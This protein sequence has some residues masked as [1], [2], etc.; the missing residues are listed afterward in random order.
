MDP[1]LQAQLALAGEKAS[2]WRR[3]RDEL[4]CAARAQGATLR[5][6]AS[7]VGLTDP[8]VLHIVRRGK[9][10]DSHQA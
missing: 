5:E 2:G 1:E 9:A 3:R 8:A 7:A 4:I 6:I 10:D